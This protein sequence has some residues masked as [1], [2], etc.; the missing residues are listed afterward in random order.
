MTRW[1]FLLIVILI[2]SPVMTAFADSSRIMIPVE[3]DVFAD[4]SKFYNPE[5]LS[6]MTG[7]GGTR[8]EFVMPDDQKEQKPHVVSNDVLPITTFL[9]FNLNTIPSSTLFETVTID[10]AKLRLFF[11]SPDNSDAKLYVFTVSYCANDQWKDDSLT[12]ENRPCQENLNA[13]DSVIISE[14]DIPNFVELDIVGAISK[15]NEDK[16]SKVTLVLD[17]QPIIFDVEYDSSDIGKVTNYIQDN[18]DKIHLSD[19][20]VNKQILSD[21]SFQGAAQRDFKGIWSD[22]LAKELLNMK[23]IDVGFVDGELNSLSYS[24][25]NSHVLRL[26]SS[27]SAQLGHATSPTIIVNYSINPSVFNNAVMFGITVVL[28][29][30]TILVPLVLWVYKKSKN[31]QSEP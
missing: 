23:N 16:K 4:K 5:S 31:N 9:K 24:V 18:W 7:F 19:F 8:T 6:L 30:L 2:C 26:A 3:E 13:I 1:Y 21:E 27:E 12:W 22:Y 15:V 20:K 29:T 11:T 17:A 28:P 25:T 14:D 10:D